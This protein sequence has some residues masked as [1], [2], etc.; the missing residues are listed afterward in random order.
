MLCFHPA[1]DDVTCGHLVLRW[2][3]YVYDR[4]LEY[5]VLVYSKPTHLMADTTTPDPDWE[6]DYVDDGYKEG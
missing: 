6:E 4:W 2:S 1:S 3:S 5:R